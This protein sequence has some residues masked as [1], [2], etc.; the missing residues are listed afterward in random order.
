MKKSLVI[1][2]VIT[3]L[4]LFT[5]IIDRNNNYIVINGIKYSTTL[6]GSYIS[7]FPD[8]GDYEVIV[9]C[10]NAKSEWNYTKWVAEIYEITGGVT[11]NISF[12]SMTATNLSNYIID[13][14]GTTQ[15]TGQVIHE[16]FVDSSTTYDTGYRY[17]GKNPNNYIFFNNELWR[18]IGVFDES[19]H[20]ISNTKLV[21]IIRND[22]IGGYAWNTTTVNDWSKSTLYHL[23]N[24]Y[25]YNATDGTSS[26]Y[27]YHYE[28]SLKNECDFSVIGIQDG[29]RSMI[30][31]DVI[32]YLGG[33]N[34]YNT[35]A[36]NFYINERKSY[37]VYSGNNS[38]V[39]GAVGLIYVSD[40]GYSALKDDRVT[41]LGGNT[42]TGYSNF[43]WVDNTVTLTHDY[44][45]DYLVYAIGGAG[46]GGDYVTP[47]QIVRPVLYLK[48][49]VVKYAG[50]GSI[51]NPYQIRL[52]S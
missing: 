14:T 29:Y 30:Q 27:C 23:L 38:S 31:N 52:E 13:L 47:P 34:T 43:A 46:I 25:Y 45:T 26:N 33:N 49:N 6:N 2:L 36:Q 21:K 16:T 15:G 1:L 39:S 4:V 24:D 8:K 37:K 10:E 3:F 18:I 17:E 44:E 20:G 35:T 9:E 19:S 11:C 28:L 22:P 51:S 48:S 32:W 40:Y 7:S 5:N 50:D 42:N 41:A 12:A